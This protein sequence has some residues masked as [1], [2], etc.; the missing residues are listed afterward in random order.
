MSS[1]G[2]VW[3]KVVPRPSRDKKKGKMKERTQPC[4]KGPRYPLENRGSHR[5]LVDK[6]GKS[7]AD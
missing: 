6:R 4:R 7:S 5:N 1:E 2:E 3:R